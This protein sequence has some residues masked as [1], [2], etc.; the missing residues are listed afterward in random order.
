MY[1]NRSIYHKAILLAVTSSLMHASDALYFA[2]SANAPRPLINGAPII[3][4]ISGRADKELDVLQEG[5]HLEV[6]NS[7]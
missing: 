3:R 2:A 4:P 7:E 6:V 5:A 1:K